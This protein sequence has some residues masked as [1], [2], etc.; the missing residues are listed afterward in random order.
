MTHLY[1]EAEVTIGEATRMARHAIYV[2]LENLREMILME[3]RE[4]ADREETLLI[5]MFAPMGL[6]VPDRKVGS[7]H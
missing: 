2:S 4:V 3:T 5:Q 7:G 6:E 1:S